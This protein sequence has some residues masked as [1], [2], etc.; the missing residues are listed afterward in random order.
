MF[1]S[2]AK[3]F[4]PIRRIIEE[5]DSLR[6]ALSRG[7]SDNR[8]EDEERIIA[9][10]ARG[11]HRGAIGGLWDEV[12]KLQHD[13]LVAQGLQPIHR[14]LDVG[15][16][17]LRGGV[18]FIAYLNSGNYWGVDLNSSLIEA[19]W[20]EELRKAKLQE[21]QPR[22]QL[23]CLKGFEFQSLNERFEFAIAL[24]VFTHMNLNNIRR[25]LT[26]L[27]PVL[28]PGGKLFATFFEV[29]TGQDPEE[30]IPHD[31][32]GIVTFSHRDPFHYCFEDFQHAISGLPLTVRY[33]G[34]WGHPRDQRMLEFEAAR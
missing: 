17:S 9:L 16:G 30:P 1:R 26:R 33:H 24:S 14:L 31:P 7:C 11:D 32:G 4:P 22:E 2:L 20:N 34:E 25:C 18:H 23:V 19:G 13:Y 12:G 27:S 5:R 21:R 8:Y 29:Q 10:V 28:E 3:K 15:C 6:E